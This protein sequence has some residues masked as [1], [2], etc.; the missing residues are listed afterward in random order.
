M[1]EKIGL[2]FVHVGLA[3]PLDKCSTHVQRNKSDPV[4]MWL[5]TLCK[6]HKRRARIIRD[7]NKKYPH[8]KYFFER[9][10]NRG[11]ER[12]KGVQEKILQAWPIRSALKPAETRQ[13]S[14]L[15]VSVMAPKPVKIDSCHPQPPNSSPGLKVARWKR[16]FCKFPM[17]LEEPKVWQKHKDWT[18]SS[19][20]LENDRLRS[21]EATKLSYILP[22]K[23]FWHRKTSSDIELSQGGHGNDFNSFTAPNSKSKIDKFSKITNWAKLKTAPQ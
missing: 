10:V 1:C 22:L 20:V 17:C 21:D 4:V 15:F 16:R 2:Q 19:R 11:T 14:A 5:Q 12:V 8:Q 7:D 13:N 18:L 3:R 23:I 9:S 6:P